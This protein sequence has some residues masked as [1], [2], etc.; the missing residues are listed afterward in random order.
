MILRNTEVTEWEAL[1]KWSIEYLSAIDGK[2]LVSSSPRPTFFFF[3]EKKP[4]ATI[5]DERLWKRHNR[6]RISLHEFWK[7]VKEG[8]EYLYFSGGYENFPRS[9][10][11]DVEPN[12]FLAVN[13]DG[14]DIM[15]WLGGKDV[16]AQTHYDHSHNMYAQIF[17]TKTFILSPPSEFPK[18]YV[19]PFSH[20]SARQSQVNFEHPLNYPKFHGVKA[21]EVRSF[22]I[23]LNQIRQISFQE[24][25]SIFL[26]FG[27]IELL[28]QVRG[29]F[30][31]PSQKSI[32]VNVW[33]NS[34]E[35]S[36]L[37]K[38]EA[39]PIPFEEEWNNEERIVMW[40]YYANSLISAFTTQPN[41]FI[42]VLKDRW[43]SVFGLTLE[44]KW[45][46]MCEAEPPIFD[47]SKFTNGTKKVLEVLSLLQMQVPNFWKE[48]GEIVL[49]D[50]LEIWTEYFTGISDVNS[51]IQNCM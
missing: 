29:N 39:L 2:Y 33:C 31:Y 13:N 7:Q 40:K 27:F 23:L 14:K 18:L 11:T 20:P 15:I 34:L 42:S 30:K 10:I 25:F 3:N 1:K 41:E 47:H 5:I 19:H 9:L 45:R 21:F 32:S 48:I 16:T 44:P 8:K 49:S 17:G 26:H 4:L 43:S 46:A 36:I 37:E 35:D 50:Y 12:D 38:L 24:M 51:F 28:Q 6:T 22:C